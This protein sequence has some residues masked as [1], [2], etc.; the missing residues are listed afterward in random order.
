MLAVPHAHYRVFHGNPAADSLLHEA[1]HDQ[2]PFALRPNQVPDAPTDLHVR[3]FAQLEVQVKALQLQTAPNSLISNARTHAVAGALAECFYFYTRLFTVESFVWPDFLAAVCTKLAEHFAASDN[4]IVQSA[5]LKVFQRVKAHVAQVTDVSKH[6]ATPLKHETNVLTRTLTLQ[7]VATMPTL[8]VHDTTVQQQII[9]KLAAN[10][11]DERLAAIEAASA[12]LP[13]SSSYRK[14]VLELSL[15]KSTTRLCSLVPGSVSNSMEAHQAWTHCAELYERFVDDKSAVASV[16]AMTMLTA[17]YPGTL[18]PMHEQLLLHVIDQDPRIFV[19]NF[20]LLVSQQLFGNKSTTGEESQLAKLLEDVFSRIG[21]PHIIAGRGLVRIKL[22]ALLLLE[23]WSTDHEVGA[24]A[25]ELLK[26]IKRLLA[27]TMDGRF[28]KA[29][30]SIISNIVRHEFTTMGKLSGQSVDE[31]LLLLHPRAAVAAETTR[32]HALDA[33][34][35]LCRD[36]PQH[37]ATRV[38]S[39]LVE[40]LFISTHNVPSTISKLRRTAVFRVLGDLRPLNDTLTQKELRMLLKEVSSDERPNAFHLRAVAATFFIWTQDIVLAGIDEDHDT[41]AIIEEFERQLLKHELYESHAERYEMVKLA[42]LRGR[43]SL[44]LQLLELIVTRADSECFGGWLL[45][46]RTLCEA[47]SRIATDRLVQLESLHSLTRTSM[48]LQAAR[49]SSFRFELQLH[50]VSL[51]HE[52]MQLL[53]N[54]QQLAGETAFT[55]V[56]GSLN[57]RE[58]RLSTQLRKLACMYKALRNL[59]LGANQL[60]LDALQ[61]HADMCILL[62]SAVDGFLLLRPPTSIGF[63]THRMT[64]NNSCQWNF[65][66]LKSLGEDVRAKLDRFSKLSPSRQP[67]VGARVVQ[68]VLKALCVIPPILPRIFFCSRMRGE[69]RLRSSAQFLTFSENAAF[70]TKPRSRSQLGVSLGTDFTSVLKGVLAFSRS[71]RAYW[72]KRFEAIEAEI[73]VCL[74]GANV[75]GTSS[76]IASLSAYE[77]ADVSLD[78]M[79]VHHRAKTSISLGWNQAVESATGE[80]GHMTLY[81]PF[82]A[83]VHVKATDLAVKGSFVLM[84]KLSL[85][86]RQGERW[87]LAATGCRRG[88]IVY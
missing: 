82:M 1:P 16:R 54:A 35:K 87:P 61:A 5:I 31:L 41:T 77:A 32:Y 79:L 70:T 15:E 84:A 39:Q 45:A 38:S 34:S 13:L 62:A 43:F 36:Y 73:L 71:A 78:K 63:L 55:N 65:E 57:G 26:D 59:L 56:A 83:P 21:S 75:N 81:L 29:Y 50:L 42:M 9:V 69:R 80:D 23:T 12:F 40:L 46:L 60:D 33:L 10:D 18:L 20:T 19:R 74:A 67:G 66:M 53:Q 68:Q 49:T 4:V 27:S 11:E 88:F 37:L 52:W 8:L 64:N 14:D 17:S 58:G 7:L 72:S 85:V 2:F 44:A 86:D 47:E 48:L 3:E 6:L 51:R 25:H 24:K 76:V 28:G 22:S 30:T